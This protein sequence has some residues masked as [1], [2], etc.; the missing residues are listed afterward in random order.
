MVNYRLYPRNLTDVKYSDCKVQSK[1]G[2]VVE[3]SLYPCGVEGTGLMVRDAICYQRI[4]DTLRVLNVPSTV[5]VE[6]KRFDWNINLKKSANF[7]FIL[8]KGEKSDA[9]TDTRVSMMGYVVSVKSQL[10]GRL[11]GIQSQLVL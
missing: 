4:V 8:H 9:S 1:S 2:S 5:T 7:S 6:G 10:S 3:L 11:N